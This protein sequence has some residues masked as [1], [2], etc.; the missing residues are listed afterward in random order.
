MVKRS[1]NILMEKLDRGRTIEHVVM[2]DR[3]ALLWI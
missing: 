2:S 3:G 1:G